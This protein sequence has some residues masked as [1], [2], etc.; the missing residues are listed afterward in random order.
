M[1][2][3]YRQILQIANKR[4]LTQP[5]SGGDFTPAFVPQQPDAG[6]EEEER[7]APQSK[8][9]DQ[10]EQ[11]PKANIS[12]QRLDDE[13]PETPQPDENQNDLPQDESEPVLQDEQDEDPDRQGL[14][15]KVPLAHLVYKRK[16]EDGT[17]EEMWIYNTGGERSEH[18][19]RKE[20]LSGTDIV[21]NTNTSEDGKQYYDIW[22]IGNA[23]MICI[24][25]LP[26]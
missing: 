19:I 24:K 9:P 22:T 10:G 1:P 13:D 23:Q 20:I 6:G 7:L 4:K 21:A 26:N 15:R 8:N 5:K 12:V 3:S 2:L 11:P 25:G 16:Q 17:Y 18:S 14:I